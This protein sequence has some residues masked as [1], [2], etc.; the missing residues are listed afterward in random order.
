MNSTV[1]PPISIDRHHTNSTV[2]TTIEAVRQ[3]LQAVGQ[4]LGNSRTLVQHSE[5]QST[6]AIEQAT[7]MSGSAK[8]IVGVSALID[9]IAEKIKL[10]SLNA[11]IES[12]HAGDAGRGFSVVANEVKELA[13]EAAKANKLIRNKISNFQVGTNGVIATL[14]TLCTTVSKIRSSEAIVHE[15]TD[16]QVS[17]LAE[18]KTLSQSLLMDFEQ[19]KGKQLERIALALASN[20]SGQIDA[21]ANDI[22]CWSTDESIR[23]TLSRYTDKKRGISTLERKRWWQS[24]KG[25]VAALVEKLS[26]EINDFHRFYKQYRQLMIVSNE[27]LILAASNS[28]AN[29]TKRPDWSVGQTVDQQAWFHRARYLNKPHSH[30]SQYEFPAEG[31]QSRATLTNVSPIHRLSKTQQ[32]RVGFLVAQID[33]LDLVEAVWRRS[34]SATIKGNDLKVLILDSNKKILGDSTAT[35]EELSFEVDTE[36]NPSGHYTGRNQAIIAF[37]KLSHSIQNSKETLFVVVIG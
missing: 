17:F 1:R 6:Q 7:L 23:S 36:K 34:L 31:N 37:A 10:V 35:L 13:I 19:S 5:E 24:S 18:A 4:E 28:N 29:G 11:S 12:A 9:E 32:D 15:T 27:G 16:Q 14:E 26:N 20:L 3:N 25:T 33:W 30:V 2:A 21:T 22:R 8:E